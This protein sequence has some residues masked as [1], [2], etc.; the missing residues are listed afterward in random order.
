MVVMFSSFWG[1]SILFSI[2]VVPIYIS[3]SS[4]RGFPLSTPSSASI[5][6][7]LLMMSILI[8]VRSLSQSSFDLHFLVIR[9]VEHLFRCFFFAHLYLLCRNVY[10]DL[11]PIFCLAC[12]CFSIFFLYWVLWVVC[13]NLEMNPSSVFSFENI[14][15]DSMDCLFLFFM[16]YFS[17]QKL[18]SLIRFQFFIFLLIFI[19]QGCES[20][21]ISLWFMSESVL[22]IFSSESFTLF[23]LIW[24]SLINFEFDFVYGIRRC[25][26]FILLHLAIQFPCTTSWRDFHF[27]IVYSC[28]LLCRFVNHWCV[29]FS[30]VL[31]ISISIF[32]CQYHTVLMPVAL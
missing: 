16:V 24:R 22:P 4:V 10:L 14:F 3:T 26:H 23:H 12:F 11:L 6:Y 13:I 32:W 5:V 2:T 28:L 29:A 31:L 21:K 17:V 19:T 27:S 9:D 15:S 20:E 8:G 25:S 1:T 18:L 30:P 7:R